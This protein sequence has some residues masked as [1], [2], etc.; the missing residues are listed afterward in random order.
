M[1]ETQLGRVC[2]AAC[3]EGL[4]QLPGRKNDLF[5]GS[6]GGGNPLR[7]MQILSEIDR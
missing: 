1:G 3:N 2:V 6:E 7:I 5:M 4:R